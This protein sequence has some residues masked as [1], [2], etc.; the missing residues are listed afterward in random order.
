MSYIS[1]ITH[2][3]NLLSKGTIK[4]HIEKEISGWLAYY[5]ALKKFKHEENQSNLIWS[6]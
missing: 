1:V 6:A 4:R 3:E 2:L 5:L